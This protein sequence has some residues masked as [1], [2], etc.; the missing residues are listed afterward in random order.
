MSGRRTIIAFAGGIVVGGVAVWYNM[1]TPPIGVSDDEPWALPD[2]Q[3]SEYSPADL[4]G[5]SVGEQYVYVTGTLIG[6]HVGYPVNTWKISCDKKK[7]SCAVADVEEIGHRQLG[8][9]NDADWPVVSWTPTTIVIQ[10]EVGPDT[11]SCARNTITIDRQK[12][13]VR[14]LSEPQN[15]GSKFCTQGRKLLGAAKV[16]DWRI[17]NPKQPWGGYLGKP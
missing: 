9:I 1:H 4:P 2:F 16:E 5:V 3:Y 8:E 10:D 7:G 12:K 13:A 14:Y 6:D 11:S 17:G 15:S